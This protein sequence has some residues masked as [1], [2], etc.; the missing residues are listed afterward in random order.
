MAQERAGQADQALAVGT[1]LRIGQRT[2]GEGSMAS[3]LQ[4]YRECSKGGSRVGLARCAA[5][6]TPLLR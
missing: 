1:R 2:G 4:F 6:L 3:T 5:T